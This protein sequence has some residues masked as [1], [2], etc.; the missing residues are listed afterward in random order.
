MSV[1]A[2][3]LLVAFLLGAGTLVASSLPTR[4]A[5]IG[6][7]AVVFLALVVDSTWLLAPLAGWSV[8]LADGVWL[9]VF[10][11]VAL[12]ASLTAVHYDAVPHAPA[13]S[14]PGLRDLV[15]LLVVVALFG[16]IVWLLPV[17]LDT[18]AQGFGHLALALRDSEQF[19]SLAPWHTE[20]E[21]LY[22]PG[23]TGLIAHLSARF[24]IG[25]HA[26]ELLFSAAV[27]VLFVWLA[28]DFGSELGGVRTG[29]AF[30]LTALG[31]TGLITAFMD[32]HYSALLALT[33]SL[34]FITF[35]IRFVY[36][37][38]WSNALLAAICLAGVPFSQPDTTIALIIGYVPWL[39]VIWLAKPR[40]K[41]TMWL[42]IAAVIP[43]AALVLVA[44]WLANI[45]DLLETDI[46]S[47][48]TVET[49]HW[50]TLVL[51]HGGIV[52]LL[53]AAGLVLGV[54]RRSPTQLLM[55]VWLVGIVEFSTLGLLEKVVPDLMEPLLK[56]D[57]P[58]SLAWHGP[59][60]PYLTLGGVTLVWLVDQLGRERVD[61]LVRRL[62][63]PLMGLALIVLVSLVVLFDP[64]LSASKDVVSFYGAFSSQA[65]VDA[66]T[67]LRDHAPADTRILNHPGPHEA[68]WAPVIT[69]RDTVYFRSQPFFRGVAAS[70]AEQD[71][72]RV[73]WENPADPDHAALLAE[74]NIR[75]VLVPQVF[76]DPD[77]FEDMLRWRR[78][79]DEAGAYLQT[80]VSEA[81]YLRLVY[82]K[83]GAQVY[84]LIAPGAGD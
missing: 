72:L 77:S 55:I 6:L 61:R 31:G 79:L 15:M 67:W 20:I 23:Y 70:Q 59:I 21:Y 82:E 60:I 10:A 30:L 73:F 47:P 1:A 54:Q 27:A 9:L 58:F 17:P 52:V 50:R 11:V 26:L 63:L 40:P 32:S 74:H 80:P 12:V 84:E 75:Y 36:T 33:F 7:G 14:W 3:F 25:I 24:D 8:A 62:A 38:Q 65:D 39:A 49:S 13:W 19:T 5:R 83:D 56:Y 69:E 22:S 53:A 64:V 57:Y 42:V 44:P 78:P 16:V 2:Y 4:G 18:D 68:D 28:Y 46:E 45:R 51:T 37:Q 66:M 43:L 35:V 76:G 48:F 81:S 41:I 29:R 34:A 71:T